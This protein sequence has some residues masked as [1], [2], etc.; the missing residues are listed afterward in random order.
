MGFQ[1]GGAPFEHSTPMAGRLINYSSGELR[2][3]A[4]RLFFQVGNF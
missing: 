2:Q 3:A 4:A 1:T